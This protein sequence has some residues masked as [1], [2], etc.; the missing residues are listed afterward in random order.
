MYS[1]AAVFTDQRDMSDKWRKWHELHAWEKDPDHP[2]YDVSRLDPTIVL[3]R[4]EAGW[5]PNGWTRKVAGLTVGNYCVVGQ[6]RRSV[7]RTAHK[8]ELSH[9]Y[10][11]RTR[12]R[13]VSEEESH[14]LFKEV[15]V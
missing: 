2:P 7:E 6:G 1:K 15:G 12:G 10:I 11:N 8:H 4:I 14:K 9:V 5:V 13:A 3:F